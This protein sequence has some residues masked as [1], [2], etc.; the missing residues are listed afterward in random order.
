MIVNSRYGNTADQYRI[1]LVRLR[2]K[3]SPTGLEC[4]RMISHSS[5]YLGTSLSTIQRSPDLISVYLVHFGSRKT[6]IFVTRE[7]ND[8]CRYRLPI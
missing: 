8:E 6:R 7:P 3:L 4:E 1:F 2:R 5:R